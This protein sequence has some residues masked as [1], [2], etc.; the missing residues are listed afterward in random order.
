MEFQTC[1]VCLENFDHHDHLPKILDCGHTLCFTCIKKIQTQNKPFCP[2][3]RLAFETKNHPTNL[4]VLRFIEE[5]TKECGDYCKAHLKFKT[6]VCLTDKNLLCEDCAQDQKH[7]QHDIQPLHEVQF[8][9]TRKKRDLEIF[10]EHNQNLKAGIEKLE[11]ARL[12]TQLKI[13]QQ[14]EQLRSLVFSLQRRLYRYCNLLA[15]KEES[16]LQQQSKNFDKLRE[17]IRLQIIDLSGPVN[18]RF[19][20]T[21]QKNKP[22]PKIYSPEPLERFE[23][24]FS[25]NFIKARE[26]LNVNLG[27]EL[28]DDPNESCQEI[29][30]ALCGSFPS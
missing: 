11:K 7:H 3:D 19:I 5:K 9:A 27:F 30:F 24:Q 29:P 15:E 17:K 13:K 18:E 6:M 10:L 16:S 23:E 28:E 1:P 4:A 20:R 14:S 8:A 25:H 26:K 12:K 21:L 22:L 2:E